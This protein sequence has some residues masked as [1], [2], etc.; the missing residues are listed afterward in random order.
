MHLSN[1]FI[2]C[3]LGMMSNT[4]HFTNIYYP[5]EV[6]RWECVR[7]IPFAILPS[8]QYMKMLDHNC[9]ELNKVG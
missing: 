4:G 3:G 8:F 6:R 1:E 5:P 7:S 2:R 9:I